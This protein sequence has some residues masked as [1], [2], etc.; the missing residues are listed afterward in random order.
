MDRTGYSSSSCHKSGKGRIKAFHLRGAKFGLASL[1]LMTAGLLHKKSWFWIRYGPITNYCV[2]YRCSS[3]KI[4]FL[5]SQLGEVQRKL[6]RSKIF[7]M[8]KCCW[9]G[10][11]LLMEL[12]DLVVDLRP[13]SPTSLL[14]VPFYYS[15][16]SLTKLLPSSICCKSWGG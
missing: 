12:V 13:P 11:V 4:L 1:S 16:R 15:I 5:M 2:L 14:L 3:T 7:V 6:K 10:P 9:F 8:L